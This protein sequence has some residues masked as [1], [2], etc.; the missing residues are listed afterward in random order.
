MEHLKKTIYYLNDANF[1]VVALA[2]T[3][4]AVIERYAYSPY[5]EI[6]ILDDDYDPDS[7]GASDVGNELLFQ[8]L[9]FD[10]YTGPDQAGLWLCRQMGVKTNSH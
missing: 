5:G 10:P 2:N 1:N 8:G 4:G 6:N 3:S 9:R 7:D